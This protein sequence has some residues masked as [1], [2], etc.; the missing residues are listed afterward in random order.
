MAKLIATVV[1][2]VDSLF[3]KMGGQR[4]CAYCHQWAK[5][6]HKSGENYFCDKIHASIYFTKQQEL[7]K[8]ALKNREQKEG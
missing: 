6:P 3:R 4:L 5:Q 1:D 7:M 2:G 8:K